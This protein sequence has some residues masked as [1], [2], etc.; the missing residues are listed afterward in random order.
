MFESLSVHERPRM[1]RIDLHRTGS[2]VKGPSTHHSGYPK[3][4]RRESRNYHSEHV[5]VSLAQ[6][7]EDMEK[8]RGGGPE[9]SNLIRRSR[10]SSLEPR[11]PTKKEKRNVS[12]NPLVAVRSALHRND[13]MDKEFQAVWYSPEETA[14]ILDEAKVLVKKMNKGYPLNELETQS[15]RGLECRTIRENAKRMDMR[16]LARTVVC[17]EQERLWEEGIQDPELLALA[18]SVVGKRAL[19]EARRRGRLDEFTAAMME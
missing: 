19:S 10:H 14:L 11:K 13:Y 4:S 9:D 7:Q 2:V 5:P 15:A 12:F 3:P 16:A 18:Y 8:G 1:P 17:Q 6:Q